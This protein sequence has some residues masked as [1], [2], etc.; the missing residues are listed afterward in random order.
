MVFGE[1]LEFGI[2][3]VID[4]GIWIADRGTGE[5]RKVIDC[6]VPIAERFLF[7]KFEIRNGGLSGLP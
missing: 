6:G 1:N 2:W 5:E 3:N 7:G 4:R